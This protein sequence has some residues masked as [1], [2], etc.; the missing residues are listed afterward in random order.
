M[1]GGEIVKQR[2]QLF[3]P[4]FGGVLTVAF[5]GQFQDIE[6]RHAA[7]AF[8]RVDFDQQR[9]VPEFGADLP[10]QLSLVAV[11]GVRYL[12]RRPAAEVTEQPDGGG[13]LEFTQPYP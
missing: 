9:M 1:R 2:R 8:G 7:A 10:D 12:V 11:G 4:D 13:R 5:L 6:K 3:A